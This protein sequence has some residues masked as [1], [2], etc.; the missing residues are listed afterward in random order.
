MRKFWFFYSREGLAIDYL[1][2]ILRIMINLKSIIIAILSFFLIVPPFFSGGRNV[3]IE[4]ICFILCGILVIL[5]SG[6][7]SFF[8]G[9]KLAKFFA[10]RIH[11]INYSNL[12][13]F[14]LLFLIILVISFSGLLGLVVFITATFLGL[15]TILSGSRRTLLMGCLMIPALLLYLPI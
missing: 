3:Y 4:E 9:I 8:I 6:L 10:L 7:F 13:L 2:A 1:S 5:F 12:S 14:I 15:F 11:K